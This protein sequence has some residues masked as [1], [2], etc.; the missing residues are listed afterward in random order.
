MLGAAR[1]TLVPALVVSWLLFPSTAQAIVPKVYDNGK[2]F[3]AETVK[4]ADAQIKLIEEKYKRD[5]VVETFAT[6]PQDVLD[7]FKYDEKNRDAFFQ[8]W[9]AD[10]EERGGVNGIMILLSKDQF[11]ENRTRVEVGVGKVTVKRD[12][13]IANRNDLAK[14]LKEN[15][16]EKKY[17]SGLLD[18]LLY[19]ENTLATQ[20]KASAVAAQ[21]VP[22]RGAKP[23]GD[24][25]EDAVAQPGNA[26]L[27]Y[28]CIGLCVL[29]GIWLVMGLVLRFQRWGRRWWCCDGRRRWWLRLWRR[30]G[31]WRLHVGA[32]GRTFWRN[33]RQL[34]LQ[35]HVRRTKLPSVVLGRI[36]G[37]RRRPR[38]RPERRSECFRSRPGI[39]QHG[40]RRRHG[41]RRW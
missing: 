34:D 31:W 30:R 12:F 21:P 32:H 35:H 36:D 26:W 6:I 16:A 38:G 33:G 25:A 19:V 28:L 7:R 17:D 41:R 15:I 24:H 9:I 37:S 8:K 3:D 27:G 20:H 18:G 11:K 2:F 40:R 1:W 14:I 10:L 4:K 23:R 29:A 39:F 22:I 5:V 13:T